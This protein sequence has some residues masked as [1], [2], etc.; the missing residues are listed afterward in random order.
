MLDKRNLELLLDSHFPIVVIETHE[1]ARGLGLLKTIAASR[2]GRL[3][4]WS[5]AIGLTDAQTGRPYATAETL[6]L[7]GDSE[8]ADA[9]LEPDAM[10]ATVK[11]HVKNAVV[12][13]LDFHPYL[14]NPR[15]VRLVREI[16]QNRELNQVTLVL[17][18]HALEVPPELRSLCARFELS[19]PDEE[20]IKA[21][22]REE[23]QLW[24]MKNPDQRL[25]VDRRA[26]GMLVRN[27]LGMTKSDVRRLVRNAI[28]QDGAITQSDVQEVMQAKYRLVAQGGMLSYEYDTASFADVG[29]FDRL[30]RWLQV[31]HSHFVGTGRGLPDTPKGIL[32]LGVQGGGKSLAAKAVAGVWGVP[33]LRLDLGGVY[34]KYIGETERNMREAL[35]SAELLAPCVLWID[36]IEKGIQTESDG[37]TSQRVLGTLLTWMAEKQA[38]VFTVATANDIQ[39]LPPELVRKGR[40]DE[41]FF[42]DLPDAPVRRLIVAIHLR[43]RDL[44]PE[45]FDLDAIAAHSASFSG[46]ELEQAVVSACYTAHAEQTAVTTEHVLDELRNTRP[47]A[48]VMA[49][50]IDGL[51]AWAAARTVP[52]H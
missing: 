29:G 27:L 8:Q 6:R 52:A 34:N 45:R 9:S 24:Q 2:P 43:K 50:Q 18:S 4:S 48:V 7:Q 13:L 37:G 15:I 11:R 30:K 41:I 12:V 28:Q 32:L 21:I 5:A 47:L 38:R 10:L 44:D 20:R 25:A 1:E 31:R 36:E 46:A 22:V 33:L 40:L 19:L 49:E 42:V 23:A 39:A 51:R 14:T 35:K 26:A 16:A 17:I 3:L